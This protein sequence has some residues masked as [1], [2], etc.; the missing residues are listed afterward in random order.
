MSNGWQIRSSF[1]RLAF[2]L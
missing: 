1:V 2:R